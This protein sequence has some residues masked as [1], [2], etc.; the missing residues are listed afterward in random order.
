MYSRATSR[1]SAG[2]VKGL[3][4]VLILTLAL[5]A[6]P[7]QAFGDHCKSSTDCQYENQVQQIESGLGGGGG[8]GGPARTAAVT[9]PSSGVSLP[10]TGLD[11][12]ALAVVALALTGT[13]IV[14]RRLATIGDSEK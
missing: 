1:R 11:V 3:L 5:F 7:A 4:A 8:G 9:R 6:V 10:F 2:G 13:G 12:A 14:L